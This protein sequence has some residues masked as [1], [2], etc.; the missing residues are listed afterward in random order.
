[1]FITAF[2]IIYKYLLEEIGFISAMLINMKMIDVFQG[3]LS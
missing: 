1:M 3:L 2:G